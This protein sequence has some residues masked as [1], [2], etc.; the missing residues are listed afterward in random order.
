MPRKSNHTKARLCN[1]EKGK[2]KH[3]EQIKNFST[4]CLKLKHK[5]LENQPKEAESA[6]SQIPEHRVVDFFEALANGENSLL[7][8]NHLKIGASRIYKLLSRR[9]DFYKAHA[10]FD[11]NRCNI[12]GD[13]AEAFVYDYLSRDAET[14]VFALSRQLPFLCTSID[15]LTGQGAH[16]TLIEVKSFSNGNPQGTINKTNLLQLW[17]AMEIFQAKKAKLF[18][19][20]ADRYGHNVFISDII[21]INRTFSLLHP[22][23]I[24]TLIEAYVDFLF[25]S[26][27]TIGI[28][29]TLNHK[30]WMKKQLFSMAEKPI[31][32][33]VWKIDEKDRITH[34]DCIKFGK[35][36]NE[37]FSDE[38]DDEKKSRISKTMEDF[39]K[40]C[41]AQAASLPP[42]VIQK[43][44]RK[45]SSKMTES[46]AN[47]RISSMAMN[48]DFPGAE[49]NL[50]RE[51]KRKRRLQICYNRIKKIKVFKP[52]QQTVEFNKDLFDR[53][54][55]MSK[56]IGIVLKPIPEE[57]T[58]PK[59]DALNNLK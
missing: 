40:R 37:R 33:G 17:M 22:E 19:V 14:Q 12:Q 50:S 45:T 6:V 15:F 56:P 53:I 31:K 49:I 48:S 44:I 46:Q 35:F 39:V 23:F 32:P 55:M 58:L 24:V 47:T 5:P 28:R 36:I 20:G 30:E 21:H 57:K 4:L 18:V 10:C 26:F 13:A 16:T 38:D 9:H 54:T 27:S 43:R 41:Y 34:P 1:L 25:D 8:C 7:M 3:V 2:S 29:L 52:R 59:K 11:G 51:Q 42:P